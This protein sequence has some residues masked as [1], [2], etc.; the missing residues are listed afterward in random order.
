MFKFEGIPRTIWT[1]GFVSLLM[2]VSSETVHGLLPVFLI[3]VLHASYT[4]LG[5]IEGAGEALSLIFKV[6]SGPLSDWYG[7]R[8]PLVL[9][10]YS[11]GALSKPLFAIATSPSM[12]LGARLFDRTGKGIRGA[13]R[14][15]LIADVTPEA[16]RGAAYGLRQSLDTVGAFLGPLLA[17]FLMSIS[18]GNYRFVFWI[19][20]IPGLLSVLLII[21]GVKDVPDQKP[22]DKRFNLAIL[23][24]FSSSFWFVAVI[25]AIFQL[26]RF[27]EAFLIL[28]A[29]NSGL[30]MALSPLVL[31]AMNIVYAISAY[32]MGRFSDLVPREWFLLIGFFVLS[33]ADI[34][35][36]VADNLLMVFAGIILWGIH[37]GLTQG[38][39]AAL[40]A[41]TCPKDY[42]GTAYGFFNLLSALALLLASIFAGYLWDRGGPRLTFTASALI[43]SVGLISFIFF[44]R[45]WSSK[46]P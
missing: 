17:I 18:D 21:F 1:L 41:D 24:K 29:Q 3:S 14:D 19:A 5:I 13:P 23:S 25:G 45:Y 43:V 44:R 15:A 27:S 46:N 38:I 42:R 20:V 31:V 16:L 36:A 10:G 4:N 40:V 26:A 22:T 6:I 9:L 35:L 12:V 30:S 37:L 7:K 39:L 33:I 2:D 34:F 32:P 8:K 11:M 28:R